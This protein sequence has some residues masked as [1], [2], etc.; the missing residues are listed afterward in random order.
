MLGN[1]GIPFDT[2]Q[3][4]DVSAEA[5]LTYIESARRM[6]S[7][8]RARGLA[9]LRALFRAGLLPEPPLD[10]RYEGRLL[11]LDIA[12]GLTRVAEAV[13]GRYLPW[14]GKRFLAATATGD[15]VFDARSRPLARLMWPTYRKYEVKGDSYYAFPFRT[16]AGFGMQEKDC[17]VLKIDYDDPV[18]PRLTVRRV[19]DE[20]VELA[21]G[22]YL[23][24]AHLL[25]WDGRWQLVAYFMLLDES[26]APQWKP[27]NERK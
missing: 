15:N 11:A 17:T 20:V 2:R 1:R 21:P 10:G 18:N 16:S 27:T 14:Q 26:A 23:G 24:Q 25:R 19:L 9:A 7:W 12:P 5:A 4:G 6:V 22:V 8:D 3:I 13:T